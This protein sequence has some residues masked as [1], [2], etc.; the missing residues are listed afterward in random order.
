MRLTAERLEEIRAN[1]ENK[2]P[3][4]TDARALLAELAEARDALSAIRTHH[5]ELNRSRGRAIENSQTIALCVRG[6]GEAA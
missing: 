5:V 1:A 2:F 6:L 4:W 3:S